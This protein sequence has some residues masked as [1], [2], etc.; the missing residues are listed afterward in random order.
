MASSDWVEFDLVLGSSGI[1][2]R[3]LV[4]KSTVTSVYEDN[5]L[6]ERIRVWIIAGEQQYNVDC[7][8][9][10]VCQALGFYK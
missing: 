10:R 2:E 1:K 6:D 7:S 3:V 4:R 8:Y 9:E 5:F